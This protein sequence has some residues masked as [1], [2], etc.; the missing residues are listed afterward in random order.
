MSRTDGEVNIKV[1]RYLEHYHKL[2]GYKAYTGTIADISLEELVFQCGGETY[3]T[4][5][6]PAMTSY[7]EARERVVQMDKDCLAGL[8]R[9]DITVKEYIPPSGLYLMSFIIISTTFLA[10]SSRSNF[11]AGGLLAT[12]LP[13]AFARFCWTIQPFVLYPMLVIHSLEAY[14]MA[15]GRLRK[16]SVNMQTGVWWQWLGSTFIEGFGSFRR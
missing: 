4:R 5:M 11:K 7:R 3:R 15:T 8:N 12:I 13:S 14:H 1:I 9:S 10:F 6:E 2:P 16:H